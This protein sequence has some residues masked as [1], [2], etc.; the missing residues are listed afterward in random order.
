MNR[1]QN[2]MNLE[3]EEKYCKEH[4]FTDH[5]KRNISSILKRMK[6]NQLNLN[7]YYN[8]IYD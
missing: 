6:K 2:T 5:Y 8:F 3:D 4:D 1:M 7:D